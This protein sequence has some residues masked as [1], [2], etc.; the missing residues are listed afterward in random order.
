[1]Y[2]DDASD[3]ESDAAS[4]WKGDDES[5]NE[6]DSGGDGDEEEEDDED[7]EEASE[8]ESML[9]IDDSKHHSLV[10]HLQYG[11]ASRQSDGTQ[12][13]PAESARTNVV[14]NLSR[15]VEKPTTTIVPASSKAQNDTEPTTIPTYEYSKENISVHKNTKSDDNA[16]RNSPEHSTTPLEPSR[17][18][19][20]HE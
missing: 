11:K 10:V 2:A 9:D 7:D 14:T 17:L 15:P 1:M 16:V 5:H 19:N 12:K 18:Q 4:S 13:P 20:G 3:E 8:D 6:N